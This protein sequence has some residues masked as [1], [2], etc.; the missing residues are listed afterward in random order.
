MKKLFAILI[1]CSLSL[2]VLATK[3]LGV[4]FARYSEQT[5]ETFTT[6]EVGE[7]N[8]SS[9]PEPD[10]ETI[11]KSLPSKYKQPLGKKKL[12]K[13]FIIAMLCVAGT[14]IFL[15]SALSL[16]NKIREGFGDSAIVPPEG[17][18]P[19][20]APNDLTDAIKTFVEKTR[21]DK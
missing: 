13:K 7:L 2:P 4:D 18:K 9:V 1:M 8:K 6:E 3:G 5:L 12:A 17:E 16:Y 11:P 14:S 15:Y 19:L 20:D 21:W 10:L